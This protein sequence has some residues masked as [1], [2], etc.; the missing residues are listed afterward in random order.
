VPAPNRA[1]WWLPAAIAVAAFAIAFRY[2]PDLIDR[3]RHPSQPVAG[4]SNSPHL[5]VRLAFPDG[6]RHATDGDRA[7]TS[8]A[9]GFQ[10]VIPEPVSLRSAHYFRGP[11]RDPVAEL[12]LSV[13]PRPPQVTDEIFQGWASSAAASPATLT[14]TLREL[15]GVSGLQIDR[16]IVG[17]A[18]PGG[19]LRCVGKASHTRALVFAWPGRTVTAVAVFLSAENPD[20][21]L[22]EAN[23]LIAGLDLS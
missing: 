4:T 7:P 20:A 14:P 17:Q 9:S 16:C 11:P 8:M 1:R 21:A 10:A 2:G 19:G 18:V 6:W 3:V 23:T 5:G 15:S 13:A 12:L 22:E